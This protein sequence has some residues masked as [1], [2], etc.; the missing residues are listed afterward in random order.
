MSNRWNLGVWRSS[1][2]SERGTSEF[3]GAHSGSITCS[4]TLEVIGPEN[5]VTFGTYIRNLCY[6]LIHQYTAHLL[7]RCEVLLNFGNLNLK[8][9]YKGSQVN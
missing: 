7:V 8:Q 2:I 3:E 1:K 6:R 5:C 4:P 9:K